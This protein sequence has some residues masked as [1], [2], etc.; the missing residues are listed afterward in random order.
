MIEFTTLK[1]SR[2]GRRLVPALLFSVLLLPGYQAVQAAPA[3]SI[4]LAAD[5][6][7]PGVS[8]NR[9]PD[10]STGTSYSVES[11]DSGMNMPPIGVEP[12]N[13]SS[14]RGSVEVRNQNAR[15]FF[16]SPAFTSD[17]PGLDQND[18]QGPVTSE[19]RAVYAEDANDSDRGG[20]R[21]P[22][23]LTLLAVIAIALIGVIIYALRRGNAGYTS[24]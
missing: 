5:Q 15:D 6:G 20:T 22:L 12:G 17:M 1:S 14:L 24:V 19:P 3:A 4:Q 21:H 7:V 11:G 2:L 18:S 10:T 16:D 9:T 13:D 8:G 23:L